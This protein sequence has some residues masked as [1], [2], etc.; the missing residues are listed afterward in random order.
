MKR[1]RPKILVDVRKDIDVFSSLSG[2][3]SFSPKKNSYFR[4][5]SPRKLFVVFIAVFFCV[6]FFGSVLA[7]TEDLK[8][9]ASIL[10]KQVLEEKLRQLEQEIAEHENVIVKH[11]KQGKSLQNEINQLNARIQKL[12][13]QIRS[14]NL[15]L[16]KLNQE[17]NV[18]SKKITS[19]EVE[20]ISNKEIISKTLQEIY[21][22]SNQ[23]LLM[24]LLQNPQISDFFININNLNALQGN[25]QIVLKK[26]V[27]LK[28]EYIN[29]K[30][31]LSLEYA[32]AA[33]LKS[34]QEN[35]NQMVKQLQKERK[36]ILTITKGKEAEYQKLVI[37]KK[38]TAAEV[39]KQIFKLLGGGEL[40]FE[41]AYELAKMA[42][43]A[44]GVRVALILAVL[45]R[46]SALGRN[47]GQCDYKTAMH[48]RRDTPAF[49]EIISELNLQKDLEAGIIKVSCPIRRDGAFGGAMGPAQFIPSTWNIYKKRVAEITG[50][51]PP[52]PWRNADAFVAT[53]LYL[54]DAGAGP[55]SSLAKQREAAAKYYAG[56]RW[57]RH[58]WTYGDW[59]IRRATRFEEDIAILSS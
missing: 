40:E 1:L 59:V 53:A 14:V 28:T 20:I 49:L 51:N 41:K 30:E 45:D 3:V 52:S 25:I 2:R 5:S 15:K 4:F 9:K 50:N 18:T 22:Q 33:A 48:P 44:T 37:E 56:S 8:V 39:R 27:D 34:Y 21:E 58:L 55:G 24:I 12:N 10:E 32:D 11:R 43:K 29:Q 35:Q 7:P 47:I 17:I 42:E 19:T 13:L 38:K 54:K 46:E 31:Q 57:R 23:N 6:M 36:D 16:K 26:L